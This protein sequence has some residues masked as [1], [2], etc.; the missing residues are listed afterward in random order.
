M[1]KPNFPNE[2][3]WVDGELWKWIDD[4]SA[5]GLYHQHYDQPFLF[6][7]FDSIE[8]R[9]DL[10]EAEKVKQ[11]FNDRLTPSETSLTTIDAQIARRAK[12]RRPPGHNWVSGAK[13]QHHFRE[14]QKLKWWQKIRL[15]S[16]QKRL[17]LEQMDANFEPIIAQEIA[18]GEWNY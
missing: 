11:D 17:E 2:I 1:P 14:T 3:L 13:Y 18:K 12:K 5:Q 16:L 15:P 6:R 9:R 7:L 8:R 4:G 10:R